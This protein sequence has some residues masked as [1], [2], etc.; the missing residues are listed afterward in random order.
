MHHQ[1]QEQC[2]AILPSACSCCISALQQAT[3][4]PNK[5][6]LA[7]KRPFAKKRRLA[8]SYPLNMSVCARI[9]RFLRLCFSCRRS[10]CAWAAHPGPAA[11]LLIRPICCR[12]AR[13]RILG[14]MNCHKFMVQFGCNS[15]RRPGESSDACVLGAGRSCN[16]SRFGALLCE[17]LVCS[18]E[19]LKM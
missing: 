7:N 4:T 13:N 9:A 2:G 14:F 6:P 3:S 12:H 5:R 8:T 1:I 17:S 18:R 19:M 16:Y 11:S 10:S 15:C